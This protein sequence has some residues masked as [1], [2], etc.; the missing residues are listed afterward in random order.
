MHDRFGLSVAA[1]SRTLGY[2][3]LAAIAGSAVV[4]ELL[5]GA[6][7]R[8]L[9]Q[10][11]VDLGTRCSQSCRSPARAGRQLC[12]RAHRGSRRRAPASRS[13][14]VNNEPDSHSIVVLPELAGSISGQ[15]VVELTERALVVDPA[16]VLAT[17]ALVR[18]FGWGVPLDDV[19]AAMAKRNAYVAAFGRGSAPT[20][21]PVTLAHQGPRPATR[22]PRRRRRRIRRWG[23]RRPGWRVGSRWPR[24]ALRFGRRGSR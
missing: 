18:Q 3:R 12:R 23:R 5:D 21:H 13:L 4:R 16:E 14:F 24:P 6:A 22:A 7:A 11:I 9:F 17:V 8:P 1:R 10:P 19:Y 15:V 2:F 20:P